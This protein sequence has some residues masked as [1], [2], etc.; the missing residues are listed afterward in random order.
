MLRRK[1]ENKY[2]TGTSSHRKIKAFM[3]STI[4]FDE[5][6]WKANFQLAE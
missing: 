3:A 6:E 2:L 1:L 5:T 4:Y